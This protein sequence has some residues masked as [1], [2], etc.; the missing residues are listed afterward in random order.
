MCID[1]CGTCYH[2]GCVLAM[3]ASRSPL[4]LQ[5]CGCGCGSKFTGTRSYASAPMPARSSSRTTAASAGTTAPATTNTGPIKVKTLPAEVE[6]LVRL[7]GDAHAEPIAGAPPWC[8]VAVIVPRPGGGGRPVVASAV[9]R[10][11]QEPTDEDRAVI[12]LIADGL[13]ASMVEHDAKNPQTRDP[14]AP[15]HPIGTIT[16]LLHGEPL[17]HRRRSTKCSVAHAMSPPPH[18]HSP[19]PP[20]RQTQVPTH[21]SHLT[22]V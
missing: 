2:S 22:D 17:V 9:L 1:G 14:A 19:N 8:G 13:S 21:M 3:V 20:S 4:P 7:A 10:D 16:N 5:A 18:H 12:N 11:A 6:A 15:L